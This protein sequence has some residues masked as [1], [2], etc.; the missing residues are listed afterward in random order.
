MTQFVGLIGRELATARGVENEIGVL[1]V[2]RRVGNPR[3][4]RADGRF[5]VRLAGR[6][7]ALDRRRLGVG[8]GRR[9]R[10]GNKKNTGGKPCQAGR[11]APEGKDHR[12]YVELY[13]FVAKQEGRSNYWD[14]TKICGVMQLFPYRLDAQVRSETACA[15]LGRA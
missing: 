4:R 12:E 15:F 7:G 14:N 11:D 8:A 2:D 13:I 3:R 6:R 10:C 5:A 1:A 9:K